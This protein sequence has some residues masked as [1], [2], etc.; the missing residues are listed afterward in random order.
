MF[1]FGQGRCATQIIEGVFVNIIFRQRRLVGTAVMCGGLALAA[2]FSQG[3]A[4]AA[5]PCPPGASCGPGGL[6]PKQGP[7]GP[8]GPNNG[9]PPGTFDRGNAQVGGPRDAPRGFS[10]PDHGAPPSPR[11]RGFGWNDGPAPGAAPRDW[12]GPSPAGGWNG[13]A[14]PGGWNRRWDGPQRDIYRARGDFGPFDYND[15]TAVPC[16]SP[17]FGGWGFWYFGVWIPL[18]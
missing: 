13:A 1:D 17:V 7:G 9:A 18:F 12:D 6:P 3:V 8:G 14:P 4:G 11:E 5:P 16:F 15:Y 2:V 10:T